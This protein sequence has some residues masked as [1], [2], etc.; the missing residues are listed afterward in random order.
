MCENPVIYSCASLT[1]I[2]S[3]SPLKNNVVKTASTATCKTTL[4]NMAF[5]TS[6]IPL[7]VYKERSPFN[8]PLPELVYLRI[9]QI[10]RTKPNDL[11][12]VCTFGK[13][14]TD[15]SSDIFMTSRPF[16][17]LSHELETDYSEI[18]GEICKFISHAQ[19]A[20]ELMDTKYLVT[21]N[22][23]YVKSQDGFLLFLG[24]L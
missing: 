4:A 17:H 23:M 19:S 8:A 13:S 21:S 7:M 3:K 14:P 18:W 11:H 2:Y 12:V 24:H 22:I 15:I 20:M 5:L 16:R 1:A 10:D 6:P 9:L